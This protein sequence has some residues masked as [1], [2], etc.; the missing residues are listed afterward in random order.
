LRADGHALRAGGHALR[1]AGHALWAG[2][3]A[4]FTVDVQ[5]GS[6][7]RLWGDVAQAAGSRS[8][9]PGGVSCSE[10]GGPRECSDDASGC[11]V[12]LAERRTL[13]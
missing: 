2:G 5:A 1:A 4:L 9:A 8:R 6:L 11:A 12:H 3:H 13:G 10:E 7:P